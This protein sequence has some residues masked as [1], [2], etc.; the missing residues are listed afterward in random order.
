MVLVNIQMPVLAKNPKISENQNLS[1]SRVLCWFNAKNVGAILLMLLA[2]GMRLLYLERY[3]WRDE[4]I[5]FATLSVNVLQNPLF[6]KVTTN[7]PLYFYLLKLWNLIPIPNP[8]FQFVVLRLFSVFLSLLNLGVVFNFL[9]KNI[10]KTTAWVFGLFFATAPLQIYYGQEIRP[11]ALV[12]L[13]IS[14]TLINLFLY[15]RTN[16]S[17]YLK[18]FV[19]LS[20]LSLITHYASYLILIS[21]IIFVGIYI[22]ATKRPLKSMSKLI[23]SFVF[24]CA[25]SITIFLVVSNLPSFSKSVAG[26]TPKDDPVTLS[27]DVSR[28]TGVFTINSAVRFKEVLVYYYWYGLFN[29]QVEASVQFVFKKIIPLLLIP[30]AYLIYK[31]KLY[32]GNLFI[33]MTLLILISTLFIS[34]VLESLGFYPFGGRHIMPFSVLWYIFVAFMFSKLSE[35]FKP[36]LFVVFVMALLLAIYQGCFYSLF[37]RH[38]ELLAIHGSIYSMCFNL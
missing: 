12:Q 23:F 37:L 26:I 20:V 14:L 6:I 31:R 8:E 38:F 2:L 1:T 7:L 5:S 3:A 15:L 21:E 24:L 34:L 13:L 18:Y 28:L 36:V 30:F 35:S 22:L 11:Y 19:I 10:N 32:S 33:K 29:Y 4:L 25:L 27:L 16:T 9:Y 17:K